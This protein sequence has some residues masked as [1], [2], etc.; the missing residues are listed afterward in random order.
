MPAHRSFL[1]AALSL[2]SFACSSVDV[3]PATTDDIV[4]AAGSA[5]DASFDGKTTYSWGGSLSE[6]IASTRAWKQPDPDLIASIQRET[7]QAL[8]SHGMTK[9]DVGADV[10]VYHGVGADLAA[11]NLIDGVDFQTSTID[12]MAKAGVAIVL[13]DAATSKRLWAGIATGDIDW[14]PTEESVATRV[15]YAV[16]RMFADFPN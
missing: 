4:A 9:V 3:N 11:M 1:I 12:P 14:T 7:D 16:D 5:S 13:V 15:A 2:A 10:L 8:A 6:I